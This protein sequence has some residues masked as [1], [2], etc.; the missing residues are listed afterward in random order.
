[1][2]GETDIQWTFNKNTNFDEWIVTS[3]VDHNEGHSRSQ[4]TLSPTGKGLF[5]GFLSNKTVKDGKVKY[6]GYCN[7]R[8]VQ[9]MRSF[10]RETYYDWT[11]YT[12]L[13]SSLHF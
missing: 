5:S 3:D 4:L 13:V 7:M 2:L 10:K 8:S 11:S 6:A 12:H 9:P 1:M